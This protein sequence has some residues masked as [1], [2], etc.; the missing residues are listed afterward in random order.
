MMKKSNYILLIMGAIIMIAGIFVFDQ[1]NIGTFL[2]SGFIGL[3][4]LTGGVAS[5]A[6]NKKKEEHRLAY[7]RVRK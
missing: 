2:L 7:S 4:F 5:I 3:L 6:A 1:V